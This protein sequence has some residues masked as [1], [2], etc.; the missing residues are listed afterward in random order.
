MHHTASW[1]GGGLNFCLNTNNFIQ[2]G[3]VFFVSFML[4]FS[5]ALLNKP[6]ATPFLML[7]DTDN[8]FCHSLHLCGCN[9]PS[10]CCS[11]VQIHCYFLALLLL[12]LQYVFPIIKYILFSWEFVLCFLLG[13]SQEKVASVFFFLLKDSRSIC[14]S[15]KYFLTKR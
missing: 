2:E 3:W 9:I 4:I 6:T 7:K 11:P 1:E 15:S 14:H 12:T 10:S 13:S 5:R 8:L